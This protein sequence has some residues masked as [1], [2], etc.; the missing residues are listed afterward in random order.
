M[1][2]NGDNTMNNIKKNENNTAPDA[3][4]FLGGN[5]LRKEDVTGPVTYFPQVPY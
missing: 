3:R 5:Y 4:D 2:T 1:K